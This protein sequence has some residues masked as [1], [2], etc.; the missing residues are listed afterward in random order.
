MKH[1]VCYWGWSALYWGKPSRFWGV[2]QTICWPLIAWNF[3]EPWA[4]RKAGWVF[5]LLP[6]ETPVVCTDVIRGAFMSCLCGFLYGLICRT[7]S[8]QERWCL[9]III[10]EH[11]EICVTVHNIVATEKISNIWWGHRVQQLGG[12]KHQVTQSHASTTKSNCAF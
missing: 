3:W 1:Y 6:G 9:D 12:S 8:L 10:V 7:Y 2:G 5:A 4:R 11:A